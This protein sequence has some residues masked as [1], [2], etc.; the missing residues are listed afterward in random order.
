MSVYMVVAWR[1][2]HLQRMGRIHPDLPANV[3]L[4]EDEWKAAYILGKKKPPEK[5]PPLGEVIRQIAKLGGFLGRKHDGQP[6]LKTL[7]KGYMRVREFV[8]GLR[9]LRELGIS[10]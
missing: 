1:L 4:S 6:G 9:N 3:L 10:P 5:V 8:E 2:A 7:W